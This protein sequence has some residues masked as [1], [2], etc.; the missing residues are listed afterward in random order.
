MEQPTHQRCLRFGFG[1]NLNTWQRSIS[2]LILMVLPA[3]LGKAQ[4]FSSSRWSDLFSYQNVLLIRPDGQRLVAATENGLFYFTPASGE[5]TKLSKAN[6]LHEVKISAFD[7]NETLKIEKKCDLVVIA[8]LVLS[9]I[10][11]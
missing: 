9:L 11:I 10:H 3:C 2:W 7:Y 1:I 5:I 6:G 8:V 4:S